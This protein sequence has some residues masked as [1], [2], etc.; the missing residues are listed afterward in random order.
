VLAAAKLGIAEI[1]ADLQ[2]HN[3]ELLDMILKSATDLGNRSKVMQGLGMSIV[4]WSRNPGR[5][6]A[7]RCRIYCR[8]SHPQPAT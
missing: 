2:Q 8:A 5:T 3:P 4:S 1:T 6:S 7:D